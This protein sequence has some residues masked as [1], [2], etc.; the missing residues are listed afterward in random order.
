MTAAQRAELD[1]VSALRAP[2]VLA[3]ALV[4]EAAMEA[5]SIKSLRIC[6]WAL[7]EGLILQRFDTLHFETAGRLPAGSHILPPEPAGALVLAAA[8]EPN[9]SAPL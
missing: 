6:P 4:A 9:G 8:G 7:R 2:Q 5:F 1:G 3:G